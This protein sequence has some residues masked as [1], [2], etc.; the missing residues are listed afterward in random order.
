[1]EGLQGPEWK[2]LSSKELG[3]RS[4]MIP[5]PTRTVLNE[6]RK[7]GCWT[8]L[9]KFLPFYLSFLFFSLNDLDNMIMFVGEIVLVGTS[10]LTGYHLAA[11]FVSQGFRRRD[12]RSNMLL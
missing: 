2:M 10:P 4:S 11:Y 3:I 12:K 6:L 7:K 1:S 8:Y 5:K 9:P